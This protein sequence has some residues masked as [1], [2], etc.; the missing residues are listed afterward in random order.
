MCVCV[1]VCVG[2]CVGVCV[3]VCVGVWVCVCVCVCSQ[4]TFLVCVW[5]TDNYYRL[6]V[7]LQVC[8]F[9]YVVVKCDGTITSKDFYADDNPLKTFFM[10]LEE[11]EEKIKED[12][13]NPAI[14]DL[15]MEEE[16]QFR[17]ARV[18]SE[19]YLLSHVRAETY[20]SVCVYVPAGLLDL[21][22]AT[23]RRQGARSQ[24]HDGRV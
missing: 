22:G 14:M 18:S 9:G 21:Q 2:V 12:L 11:E 20:C 23:G 19:V 24:S 16:I 10:K 5:C 15:S 8:S 17:Q 13:A 3:C 6:L 4:M 7:F 1:C